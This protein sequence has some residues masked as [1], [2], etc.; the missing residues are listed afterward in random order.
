MKPL[1]L[2]GTQ[3]LIER[4]VCQSW[5]TA[6][7]VVLSSADGHYPMPLSGLIAPPLPV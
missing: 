6:N 3:N 4:T 1:T 5:Q 7:S 2:L